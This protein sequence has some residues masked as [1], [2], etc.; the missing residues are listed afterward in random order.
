[1]VLRMLASPGGRRSWGERSDGEGG[2]ILYDSP[3]LRDLPVMAT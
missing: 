1:M 2:Y 3:R